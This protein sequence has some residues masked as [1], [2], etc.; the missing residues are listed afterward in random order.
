MTKAMLKVELL[1]PANMVIVEGI[2]DDCCSEELLK[3][4]FQNKKK[5][6]AGVNVSVVVT[7]R[8]LAVVTFEDLSGECEECK[9]CEHKYLYYAL[10]C[11]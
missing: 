7:G 5:S 8:G 11:T 4:Y 2:T 10:M 6:G 9:F 1:S 3:M